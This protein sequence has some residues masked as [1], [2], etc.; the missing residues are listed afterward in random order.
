MGDVCKPEL[1]VGDI[2]LWVLYVASPFSSHACGANY[3]FQTNY[4]YHI[5]ADRR[6]PIP[7]PG[8]VLGLVGTNGIGK[9]TAL[10]IL[11]GKYKP[12]L[13]NFSVR[14]FLS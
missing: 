6:L 13:G 1:F 7:R 4:N 12:N 8:Q 14:F 5:C 11:H 9:S 10:K 3:E 2:S